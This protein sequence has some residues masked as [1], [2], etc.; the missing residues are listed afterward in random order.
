MVRSVAVLLRAVCSTH[1]KVV[2]NAP[3]WQAGDPSPTRKV[4]Q[5]AP[6]GRRMSPCELW[7]DV[8][9]CDTGALT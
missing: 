8:N 6:L 7:G 4:P 1:I 9:R 3:I 5:D 2:T